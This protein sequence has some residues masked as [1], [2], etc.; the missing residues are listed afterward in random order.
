MRSLP[1]LATAIVL[2]AAGSCRKEP[3]PPPPPIA[4][5]AVVN[6]QPIPV[7]TLQRELDRLRRGA[8]G[9]AAP[10]EPKEVP[11][12]GKAL[13]GPLIDRTLLNQRAREAG[14]SVSDVDVQR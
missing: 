10:V 1:A 12:L 5:A 3:P 8:G 7:P 6:G 13:L 11:E 9:E 2:A 14:L 4:A